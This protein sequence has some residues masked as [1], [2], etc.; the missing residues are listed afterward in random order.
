M[1][2]D[3]LDEAT[4]AIRNDAFGEASTPTTGPGDSTTGVIHSSG[5]VAGIEIRMLPPAVRNNHTVSVWPFPGRARLYCLTLV[6]SD[7]ANQLTGLMDLNA[8]PRVADGDLLPINKTIYY[9]QDS[10]ATL[11]KPPSQV[12]V[13]C[14]IIK[15]KEALRETA[16]VLASV[17]DDPGYK[18]I[19]EELGATL[20]NAPSFNAITALT[21]QAAHIVGRY[22]GRVDDQPIGTV[23]NSFT[24]LHGDWDR[25]GINPV[26]VR[27]RDVDFDFELI[28]RDQYRR[29][30]AAPA[31]LIL[32]AAGLPAPGDVT[33]MVPM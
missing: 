12:H 11:A 32:P 16:G 2:L 27:T 30:A 28:I 33:T 15:S 17:K 6:V 7:A 21:M 19:I 14:S 8:F 1:T 25:L 23:I 29:Q 24:R 9:W 4:T 18:G 26:K 20:T 22:L 10:G 31:R 5:D 3:F 13:M